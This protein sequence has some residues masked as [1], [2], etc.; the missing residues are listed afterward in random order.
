MKLPIVTEIIFCTEVR[1]RKSCNKREFF[2][3]NGKSV[4]NIQMRPLTSMK[5]SRY[6]SYK[7]KWLIRTHSKGLSRSTDHITKIIF[8]IVSNS[9]PFAMK[10]SYSRQQFRLPMANIKALIRINNKV[11]LS[12]SKMKSSY[13]WCIRSI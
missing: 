1:I 13:W 10:P 9:Y 7:A 5:T 2:A 12:W 3:E 6:F 8:G 4:T 11:C